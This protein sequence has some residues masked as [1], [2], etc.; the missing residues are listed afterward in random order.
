PMTTPAAL[1]LKLSTLTPLKQSD[2]EI[3]GLDTS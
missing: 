2:E 1:P 3:C